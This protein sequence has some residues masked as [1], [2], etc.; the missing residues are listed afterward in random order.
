MQFSLALLFIFTL[1]S[2]LTSKVIS[3]AFFISI[4]PLFNTYKRERYTNHFIR[5]LLSPTLNKDKVLKVFF[6]LTQG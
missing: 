6:C 2:V 4:V 1:Q 5:L 3:F